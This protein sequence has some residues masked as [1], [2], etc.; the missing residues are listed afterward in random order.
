MIYKNFNRRYFLQ[1]S[2]AAGLGACAGR[3]L[4]QEKSLAVKYPIPS[5]DPSYIYLC[6]ELVEITAPGPLVRPDG[7]SVCSWSRRPYLDFN[8]E[9]AKFYSIPYFQ[10]YRMK[11]WDMYHI[12]TPEHYLSF[13]ISWIGYGAFCSGYVYE[14]KTGQ[15]FEGISL[16]TPWPE[17]K[18]MRDSTS[19]VS[20]FKN[21]KVKASFEVRGE[22]RKLK[23][24]FPGFAKVGLTADIEL[25]LPVTDEIICATHLTSPQRMHYDVKINCM[26]AKG[27]FCL[28]GKS[29]T[30]DP[31]KSFGMLDFGRG[32]FPPKLFWYWVVASGIDGRGKR[33]GFNLGHGNSP[34]QTNENAI[35]YDGK[36]HKINEIRVK[37][38]QDNLMKPWKAWSEDGRVDLSFSPQSVRY[39]SL[40]IGSMHSIGNP[41]LGI[42]SGALKL[43]NGETVQVKDLF[44][45][46]EWFDQKW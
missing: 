24:D 5:L 32:F 6:P 41:A 7:T 40:K 28:A 22:R 2:A 23:I 30:L 8:L 15:G 36:V 42:F 33:L 11:K 3:L 10:R 1:A 18:M 27:K 19:G 9:D 13:I 20:E 39:S 46:C 43:D 29:C 16:K 21:G 4:G 25:F 44:G 12:E 14:R 38:P 45:A 17:L 37:V 35:F 31:E 34:H 26:P